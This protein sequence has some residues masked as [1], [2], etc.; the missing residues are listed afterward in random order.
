MT[1]SDAKDIQLYFSRIRPIYH[2]LFNLAH[3]IAGNCD[4]AEY[5]LQYAM[6]DCWANG[7]ASANRHG[8]RESL[9]SSVIRTALRMS[10]SEEGKSEFDW[11]GLSAREEG[12]SPVAT[13]IV[14]EPMEARRILALRYGCGLTLRQIARLVGCEAGRVQTLLRRF[15][16]RVR[17]RL[18]GGDQRRADLL[19]AQAVR[20][21]MALPCPQAPEIGSV[22]RTFQADAASITRP[23]RLPMRILHAVLALVLAL[24]CILAFWLTAVL[25]QPAQLEAPT[26]QPVALEQ[27]EATGD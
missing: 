17:R 18:S 25:M 11:D 12:A 8:F 23:S 27:A 20:A 7:D 13:F 14:Q 1:R 10:Q 4:Q 21:Q 16:A 2:Q 6:L 3:A 15:E 24:L 26:T 5:C 9:R 22:L 19:I